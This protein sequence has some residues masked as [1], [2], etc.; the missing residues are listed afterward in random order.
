MTADGRQPVLANG[1]F[2]APQFGR[3]LCG[4]QVGGAWGCCRPIAVLQVA[5]FGA[6]DLPFNYEIQAEG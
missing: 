2:T 3:Q 1:S 4:F 6:P 5:R